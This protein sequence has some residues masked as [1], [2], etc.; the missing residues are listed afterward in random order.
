M[1][2]GTADR[3]EAGPQSAGRVHVLGRGRRADSERGLVLMWACTVCVV[4]A[5]VI[6]SAAGRIKAV[7]EMGSAEFSLDGQARSVAAAGM[8][9]AYAWFR[10]QQVQPVTDFAPRRD[11]AATPAINE[12]DD[13]A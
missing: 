13:P 11:L 4:V 8:V 9:D 10:R 12:T 1:A 5:G 6:F 7:D 3:S 2:S